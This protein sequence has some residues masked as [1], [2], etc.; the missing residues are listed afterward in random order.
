MPIY[1]QQYKSP[2]G[3][4]L[5][6]EFENQLCLCDWVYRKQRSAIDSRLQKDLNTAFEEHETSFLQEVKTQLDEYFSAKRTGFDIPLLTIGTDFQKSVWEML[7]T[8]PY[9]TTQSY[10]QL[11]RKLGNEKAIRA[12]ATTNGANALSVIIPC[13][14]IIGSNGELVGYAGGTEAKKKLLQLEGA[15]SGENQFS[16]FD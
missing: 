10:L 5:L 13:H 3:L 15:P 1:T 12:V 16:L 14:R 9:G 6:G 11:S 2:F 7:R 8:I 4:L